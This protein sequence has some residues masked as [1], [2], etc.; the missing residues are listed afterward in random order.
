MG[1]PDFRVAGKVFATLNYPSAGYG[2][3]KLAP[4][5]QELLIA[6]K[7]AVF[8][9]VKGAWGRRGCT[10]VRLRAATPAMIRQALELAWQH[11][12]AKRT[13]ERRATS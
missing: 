9:P 6:T 4:D 12:A 2:M 13:L 5:E 11:V 3:V 1:H 8:T 10:S 7:S